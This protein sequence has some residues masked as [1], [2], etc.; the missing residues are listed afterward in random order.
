[1]MANY[2]RY[3]QKIEV[4]YTPDLGGKEECGLAFSAATAEG[5]VG[6]TFTAP[7][8]SNPHDLPLSWS[9]SDESVAT[10]DEDGKVTLVGGGTAVIEASTEGDD[11]YARGNARYTL[12]VMPAAANIAQLYAD[13]PEQNDLVKVNFPMIVTYATK[14][15]AY[16]KDEEGNATLIHNIKNDGNTG[17]SADIYKVGDIIPAGWVATNDG[18]N[19]FKGLPEEVT[20]TTTV[21]YPEVES[22]SYEAD[23]N[24]VVTLMDVT[25]ETST[26]AKD[27]T[28]GTTLDGTT[29]EF[30]NTFEIA[31][32]PAGTY[33]ATVVVKYNKIR[34]T[35]YSW[36]APIEFA[37]DP[38]FPETFE[39]EVSSETL[40]IEKEEEEGGHRIIVGGSCAEDTATVEVIVPEGWD[41]FIGMS[42]SD[43]SEDIEYSKLSAKRKA[44]AEAEWAPIETML[45]Y[46]FKKTNSFV[47]PVD[48]EE[49]SGKLYLYKGEKVDMANEISVDFQAEKT[50]VEVKPEFPKEFVVTVSDENLTVSQEAIDVDYHQITIEGESDKETVT[51]ELEVPEGW[52]GYYSLS[53]NDYEPDFG[54]MKRA[55]AIA[56]DAEDDGMWMPVSE[57]PEMM[58]GIKE[59]NSLIFNVGEENQNGMF[60]LFKGEMAYMAQIYMEVNVTTAE[61]PEPAPEFPKEFVVTVSDENLTVSQEVIDVDYHQITIEGESDKET[62]TVAL[63]VPEGWDGYYSLSSN[64]FEP[65]FGG[66]KR[67]RA[68]A[69]DAEDD[70]MWMPVSELPEMMKGIKEGNSLTFNVG[71][72]NQNGMFFLFKGEMAYM[73]QIYMEVNVTKAETP[74]PAD[75]VFPE[76]FEITMNPAP[77]ETL[78]V[79]QGDFE[80]VYSIEISGSCAED[81]VVVTL[82]V[83]EG[84]DG[85]FGMTDAEFVPD[86]NNDPM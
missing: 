9:S 39:V 86:V 15:N 61:T 35:V 45:A 7:E 34:N 65:D 85:F 42:D 48:G 31:D 62:V 77:S 66:M 1:T 60:F 33:N 36:L 8:L 21:V 47:F 14:S 59:G 6:E 17:A 24:K 56:E 69:E 46:G 49:H 84:W 75:P 28:Y 26:N 44:A 19:G 67:A 4:T 20:E 43:Y 10:V 3:I 51:V 71:E 11:S 53:S 38:V 41:G 81:K 76:T 79:T 29:Y 73:A 64:D 70:G 12:T 63:E 50:T 2:N 30:Q 25:F 57:L 37:K 72:E 27:K 83:P 68:I 54:G 82:A 16:V 52:D 55:R 22:I 18:V 74:E 32:S 13:A 58:K 78:K 5:I 80:G 40:I 23:A